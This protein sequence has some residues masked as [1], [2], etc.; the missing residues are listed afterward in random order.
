MLHLLVNIYKPPPLL[1]F[2]IKWGKNNE[3]EVIYRSKGLTIWNYC[4]RKFE[5]KYS[6]GARIVLE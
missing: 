3:S 1:M 4:Y 2:L 5:V 6:I